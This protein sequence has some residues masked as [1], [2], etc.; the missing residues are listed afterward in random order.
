MLANAHLSDFWLRAYASLFMFLARMWALTFNQSLWVTVHPSNVVCECRTKSQASTHLCRACMRAALAL[1]P[2]RVKVYTAEVFPSLV[3]A[4]G[5]GLVTAFARVGAMASPFIT[6][7]QDVALM[8]TFVS[9]VAAAVITTTLPV[10]TKESP[11]N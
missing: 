8:L 11:L 10:E 3:R 6:T 5:I 7:S 2:A 9:C 1:A 4:S